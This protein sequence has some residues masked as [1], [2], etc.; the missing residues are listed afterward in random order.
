MRLTLVHLAPISSLAVRTDGRTAFQ[1]PRVFERVMGSTSSG[2][3]A[4]VDLTGPTLP[5]HCENVRDG[6]SRVSMA[7]SA[8]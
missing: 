8:S 7:V 5:Q 4:P 1:Y 3:A 2:N 6:G